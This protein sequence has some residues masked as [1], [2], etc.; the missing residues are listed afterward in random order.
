MEVGNF[1]FRNIFGYVTSLVMQS[2][3]TGATPILQLP[4]G[5]GTSIPFVLFQA[6]GRQDREYITNAFQILGDFEGFDIIVGAF[7]NND[8]PHGPSGNGFKAFQPARS[9]ARRGGKEWVST[10]RSGWWPKP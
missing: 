3:N 2:I 1:T 4:T 5:A 6:G 10:G 9:E 8:R 7:Y